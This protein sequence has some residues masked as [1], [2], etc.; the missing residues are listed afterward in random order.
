MDRGRS[1]AQR[2]TPATVR[3]LAD[4]FRY[5]QQCDLLRVSRSI[6]PPLRVS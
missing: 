1:A 2:L 6:T 3:L 5:R 4:K